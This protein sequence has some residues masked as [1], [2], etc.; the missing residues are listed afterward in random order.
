[1]SETCPNCHSEVLESD[2]FCPQCGELLSAS[3]ASGAD[4]YQPLAG[5][6]GQPDLRNHR[7]HRRKKKKPLYRKPWFVTLAILA[8]V[9]IIG[10]AVAVFYINQKFDDINRVSTPP[11]VVSLHEGEDDGAASEVKTDSAQKALEIA[12]SGKIGEFS[13]ESDDSESAGEIATSASSDEDIVDLTGTP[14]STPVKPETSTFTLK[15]VKETEGDSSNILLMGVD[16]RPGEAIDTGVRPDSLSV[17][18]LNSETGSCRILSIPRDTRTDLPGYGQTKINH[19]LA[20]GG[21]SYEQLVVEQLLGIEI[22]HYGLVDFS[23]TVE[24]VDAVGGVTVMNDA[25]F[26][27][28][29]HTFPKGE[30]QL[31]GEEALAYARFRYDEK[32]DFGRQGRQQ[33]IIRAL[34]SETDGMDVVKGA[35]TLLNAVDGHFKTDLSPREMIDLARDYRSSCTSTTLETTHIDGAIESHPDPLFNM[36]LS[37][38]VLDPNEVA[39]KVAWLLGE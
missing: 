5:V 4:E 10:S 36:N 11:P 14:Q 12:R 3:A 6:T 17:L 26:E 32:G 13:I 1:M 37:Y 38:V 31:N 27:I 9:I 29:G 2:T 35:N 30:L 39:A 23:G 19:A 34:I 24:L 20:V 18:H 15:P 21:I 22:D 16:A 25:A 8:G 33:Q 28:D 7:K